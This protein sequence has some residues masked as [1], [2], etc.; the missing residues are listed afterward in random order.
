MSVSG[1]TRDLLVA[2][3]PALNFLCHLSGIATATRAWADALAGTRARVR[4]TRKTTPG[5]RALEKYAVRAGG[6][7]NHRMA[8]WDEGLVKD[9]HVIAAGGVVEAFA[10]VRARFPELPVEV[11]VDSLTQLQAVL[12]AGAELVLL[13]NFTLDQMREAVGVNAGR[14][15]LEASGGLTVAA[16]A[17]V[18]ATGV[19]YVSVGALTHSAPILDIALDLREETG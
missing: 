12:E 5:L 16:A 19:D 7:V 9:N 4:D 3:R 18:A 14:A 15:R 6:G 2:E 11:E 1:R 13:D 10:A 17:A 8:L